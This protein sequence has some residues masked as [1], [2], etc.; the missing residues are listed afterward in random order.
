MF[1]TLDAFIPGML[2]EFD[3]PIRFLFCEININTKIAN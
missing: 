2:A 3:E 1:C